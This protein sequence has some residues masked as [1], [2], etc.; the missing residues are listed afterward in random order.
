MMNKHSVL[1]LIILIPFIISA[2]ILSFLLKEQN[3]IYIFMTILFVVIGIV[4]VLKFSNMPMK[5]KKYELGKEIEISQLGINDKNI[6]VYQSK[7]LDEVDFMIRPKD[8]VLNIFDKNTYIVISQAF[9]AN[10]KKSIIEMLIKSEVKRVRENYYLKSMMILLWP[11]FIVV[12]LFLLSIH[13]N[14]ELV[15]IVSSN[16][17][18]WLIPTM[19]VLSVIG[20]IKW[21]NNYV[22]RVEEKLDN[23]LLSMY[24]DSEVTDY[25]DVTEKYIGGVN[26]DKVGIYEGVVRARKKILK[27]G[28]T[29]ANF[30]LCSSNRFL[31]GHARNWIL[32]A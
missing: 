25:I 29:Y 2:A 15:H 5:L 8:V 12:N 21:F 18:M 16:L 17:K 11:T 4:L 23:E 3:I 24:S 9:Y 1:Y 31:C 19:I 28:K 27:R 22:S 13:I 7:T 20:N 14:I 30:R 26:E 32:L 6:K 10:N